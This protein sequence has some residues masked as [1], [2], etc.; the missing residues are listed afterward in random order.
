[1]WDEFK[2]QKFTIG[3]SMIVVVMSTKDAPQENGDLI[4]DSQYL[5]TV[6]TPSI[7]CTRRLRIRRLS[8]RVCKSKFSMRQE[9]QEHIRREHRSG[10]AICYWKVSGN[11]ND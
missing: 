7:Y 4:Y 6:G 2:T 5:G 8:C 9:T 11:K 10:L 3:E 1:M